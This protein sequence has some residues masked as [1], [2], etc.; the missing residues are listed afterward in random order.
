MFYLGSAATAAVHALLSKADPRSA[1]SW[2]AVCWLFPLGGPL[3]Y[4][5]FGIN[6]VKPRINIAQDLSRQP[7]PV[8]PE[9]D[10]DIFP[11]QALIGNALSQWLPAGGNCVE[12]LYNGEI[13]FPRMLQA[14]AEARHSI[15]LSTYIFQTDQVGM[16]FVHALAE[17]VGRGVSV[18]VLVDGIGEWY[19]WPHVTTVLNRLGV[20]AAQFLPPRLFPPNVSLNCRNHRKM[21][22][23]DA[24]Q[25]YVGGMNL[26]GREVAGSQGRRLTDIHFCILGPVIA[27]LT[28]IFTTDWQLVTTET[29]KQPSP[30]PMPAHGSVICRV[31]TGGPDEDADK[32]LLMILGAI[33]LAQ[34]QVL[35][36]TPYFIPPP[37][38]VAA[39]QAAALRGVDVALVLPLRSNLPFVDWATLHWLPALLSRG[40][41]IA[42]QQPPFSHAK[43]FVVDQQYAQIGSANFDTR[44][45]RLNFEIVV[46]VFDTNLC[47]ELAAY[48][49]QARS[50]SAQLSLAGLYHGNPLV[51]LRNSL[52]W[53]IS[54]YL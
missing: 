29:L 38:L 47:T 26:G 17:A 25:A 19:D 2:I 4:W 6:R 15:W 20:T 18:K 41:K 48:I 37:E 16:G 49:G 28:E 12:P 42:L 30:V 11:A 51:R 27:Q 33:S 31:I 43:L 35:I 32:L 9:T 34:R 36:M 10:V 39:L 46:E 22:L 23:I 1:M 7:L 8:A 24:K 44:S 53:L 45:L 50:Q 54:P 3:L 21:L 13:A 52:C 14:I 40:V 5:L